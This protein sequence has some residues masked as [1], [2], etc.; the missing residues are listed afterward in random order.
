[1]LEITDFCLKGN[2]LS[3]K[4]IIDKDTDDYFSMTVDTSTEW[5]SVVSSDVSEENRFYQRQAIAALLRYRGKENEIPE[6]F[7][8]GI[9]Y[10]R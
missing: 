1:M 2:M 8:C 7:L 6:R 5:F 9:K 4:V 3:M 10:A